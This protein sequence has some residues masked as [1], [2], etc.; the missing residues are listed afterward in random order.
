MQRKQIKDREA[1]HEAMAAV[2]SSIELLD[3]WDWDAWLM[4]EVMVGVSNP[5]MIPLM[6][7]DPQFELKAGVI[8]AAATYM[9]TIRDL[10]APLE[11]PDEG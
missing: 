9:K 4:A 10:R 1:F 7:K 8:R 2:Q 5:E 3:R 11:K 6:K